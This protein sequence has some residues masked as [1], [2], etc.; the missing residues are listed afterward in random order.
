MLGS[1]PQSYGNEEE[2]APGGGLDIDA[3]RAEVRSAALFFRA[4]MRNRVESPSGATRS[5]GPLP[6]SY[7]SMTR[8]GRRGINRAR[9]S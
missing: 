4:M 2:F 6:R 9:T 5:A 8:R 1:D 3:H 7:R